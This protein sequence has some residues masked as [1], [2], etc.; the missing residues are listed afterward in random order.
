MVRTL[1]GMVLGG[2]AAGVFGAVYGALSCL[3]RPTAPSVVAHGLYFGACGAVA[4]AMVAAFAWITTAGDR[5]GAQK[6]G[7][8]H[9]RAERQTAADDAERSE[10][11][12]PTAILARIRPRE[13]WTVP[14]SERDPRRTSD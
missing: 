2:V 12:M 8:G 1:T 6:T 4:G 5:P 7:D 9:P 3:L 11:A 13:G 14:D 10:M